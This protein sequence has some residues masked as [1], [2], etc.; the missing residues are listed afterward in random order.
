MKF[1]HQNFANNLSYFIIFKFSKFFNVFSPDYDELIR[2]NELVDLIE[3]WQKGLLKNRLK[4]GSLFLD[5]L[6]NYI[7]DQFFCYHNTSRK[8]FNLILMA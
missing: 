5:I 1:S 3:K 7:F 2:K 6:A 8:E 4:S